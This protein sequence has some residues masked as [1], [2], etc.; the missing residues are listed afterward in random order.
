MIESCKS[1]GVCLIAVATAFF[2]PAWAAAGD[3]PDPYP[4]S[5]DPLGL[6][7]PDIEFDVFRNGSKVGFHR[8]RFEQSGEELVVSSIFQLEVDVLF[9]T[10]FRYVYESEGQW[11]DGRLVHLRATVNDNG[12][13]S[14]I[15]AAATDGSMTITNG[16]ARLT[17]D[18]T[19]YP[20]NHWNADV[21]S[22]TRVL[23]TLTGR[24]N[25]VTIERRGREDV[26]TERG[27]VMATRYAYAG[28]LETEVWYDDAGR[29][30]KLRFSGRDGSVI[31]YACRRCQGHNRPQA[32]ND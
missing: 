25:E 30:V 12:K 3:R 11:R 13:P 18:D 5:P 19:F 23:N 4:R 24:I 6:Y 28:D 17:V 1:A 10:A 29:W 9:F 22:H 7:G 31:E 2:S 8:V 15:E 32:R 27:A 16:D 20:T 14:L 21:L 26:S